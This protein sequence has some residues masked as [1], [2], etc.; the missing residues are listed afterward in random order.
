MMTRFGCYIDGFNLYH[1]LDGLD[2]EAVK[3]LDLRAL[4]A[5][6]LPENAVLERVVYCTAKN[7]KHRS[8]DGKIRHAAYCDALSARGVD[9]VLG[10][11]AQSPKQCRECGEVF[12]TEEE[13]QSD[14]NV[15]LQ[16]IGDVIDGKVDGVCI[17]SADTDQLAHLRFLRDRFPDVRRHILFPPGRSKSK[18][19]ADLS[20]ESKLIDRYQLRGQRLPNLVQTPHRLVVCPPQYQLT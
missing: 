9:V 4:A 8:S 2:D 3:W 13:K 6:Y 16:A 12:Q 15:A 17:V 19:L 20:H 7:S 11:F 14:L 1:A 5:H 10:S 18:A